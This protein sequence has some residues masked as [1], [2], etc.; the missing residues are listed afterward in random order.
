MIEG[1]KSAW[2]VGPQPL[3]VSGLLL[4]G[5]LLASLSGCGTSQYNALASRGVARLRGEAK[6]QGLY[7]PAQIPGSPFSIRVPVIFTNSYTPNSGHPDDGEKIK[8]LR[9]QPP[10]LPAGDAIK[11]TYE[12][13]TKDAE[14]R[15][16]PY[17]CYVAAGEAKPGEVDKLA[18]D[19]E[20]GLKQLFPE[21]PPAWEEVDADTPTGKAIHWRKIRAV[22]PQPFFVKVEGKVEQQKLPGIFELWL[23]DAGDHVAII[24]WRSPSAVEGPQTGEFTLVG[25][26]AVPVDDAK[27]DFSKWPILT[28]GSLEVAAPSG[29]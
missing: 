18:R 25:G 15:K 17:Y 27:P 10:F 24:A 29:G 22:G 8:P 11:L 26:L 13:T 3:F 20:A 4:S 12:G 16:V 23:H 7:A 28:A 14:G 21:P 9:M 1:V 6:F 2:R 19:I 5:L